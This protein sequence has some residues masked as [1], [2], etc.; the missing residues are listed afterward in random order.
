MLRSH[1]TTFFLNLKNHRL[2]TVASREEAERNLQLVTH[3][4][5]CGTCSSF[6]DLAVYLSSQDL[7]SI[8]I[9][10][11]FRALLDVAD[12][13]E[14]YMDTGFS[15][16]CAAT[17]LHN[18]LHTNR[19]CPM[20]VNHALSGASPNLGPPNCELADCIACDDEQSGE[21]FIKYAGRTR[22]NSGLLSAIVRSCDE[23]GTLIQRDPCDDT[24]LTAP[25]TLTPTTSAPST[26]APTS[27]ETKS[28]PSGSGSTGVWLHLQFVGFG[29]LH[30]F[31]CFY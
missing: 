15:Q 19:E 16:A 23:V 25:P 8:G 24:P 22:R 11:A 2:K 26:P 20:C 1:T 29:M 12:G 3:D 6:R 31:C 28:P 4:G 17:W 9:N 5:A 30:F 21:Y 7:S 14:C 10:C 27:A 13:T 18:S